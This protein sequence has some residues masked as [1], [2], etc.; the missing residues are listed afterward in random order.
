MGKICN[1]CKI[2]KSLDDYYNDKRQSDKKFGKCKECNSKNNKK[3]MEEHK[4]ERKTY[5]KK[6]SEEQ[7]IEQPWRFTLYGINQR[8]NNINYKDYGGRGIKCLITADELKELWFRDKAYEMKEPSIDRIDNNGDYT[9]KNCRY[10]EHKENSCKDKRKPILQYDLNGNFIKEFI[11]TKDVENKLNF[12]HKSVGRVA[13]GK[14][15]QAY[16]FVWKYKGEL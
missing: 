4:E 7:K 14:R 8:C 9:F 2:E 3:W 16:G 6:Y 12:S 10:L 5:I 15:K 13:L 1:Q 11:S